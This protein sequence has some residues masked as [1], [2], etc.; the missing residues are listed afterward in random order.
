MLSFLNG[1]WEWILR[2]FFGKR[3]V[4]YGAIYH[5]D[6][7]KFRPYDSIHR[8]RCQ[9]LVEV[10]NSAERNSPVWLRLGV[11]WREWQRRYDSDGLNEAN[12]LVDDVFQN[13]LIPFHKQDS[14]AGLHV[15]FILGINDTPYGLNNGAEWNHQT[16]ADE[17]TEAV[18]EHIRD[19]SWQNVNYKDLITVWNV[20]NEPTD[21]IGTADNNQIASC[22][23]KWMITA[24]SILEKPTCINLVGGHDPTEPKYLNTWS[25]FINGTTDLTTRD[26]FINSLDILG[27]DPYHHYEIQV[28]D[29]IETMRNIGKSKWA[30]VETE[31]GW[32]YDKPDFITAGKVREALDTFLNKEPPPEFLLLYQLVDTTGGEDGGF[33]TQITYPNGEDEWKKDKDGVLFRDLLKDRLN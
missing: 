21:H 22:L 25:S 1:L 19:T 8:S 24:T 6:W 31:A 32:Y 23:N 15:C 29:T 9:R 30:V 3:S 14:P 4:E 11:T 33:L 26:A 12:E 17:F 7:W 10:T 28:A 13:I 20:D 2:T 18:A 27:I 16:E 5:N